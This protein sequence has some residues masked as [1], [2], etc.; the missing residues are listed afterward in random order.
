MKRN[1][2]LAL[3]ISGRA[4]VQVN[5]CVFYVCRG[6]RGSFWFLVVGRFF[7]SYLDNLYFNQRALRLLILLRLQ[8]MAPSIIL[9]LGL[10]GTTTYLPKNGRGFS[11]LFN[12]LQS[13]PSKYI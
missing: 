4:C 11:F 12:A 10:L 5:V 2:L 7:H 3:T 1:S 13:T 9:P 6:L 8:R